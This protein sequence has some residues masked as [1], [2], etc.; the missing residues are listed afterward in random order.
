VIRV[1]RSHHG[2]PQPP[3][4][5]E[6]GG[7]AGAEGALLAGGPG[8]P[9]ASDFVT[10]SNKLALRVRPWSAS[11]PPPGNGMGHTSGCVSRPSRPSSE[12]QDP[13]SAAQEPD[14]PVFPGVM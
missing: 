4:L 2:S 8:H 14:D 7:V 13:P 5:H 6:V 11:G 3:R 10:Q 9:A 1:E 12:R